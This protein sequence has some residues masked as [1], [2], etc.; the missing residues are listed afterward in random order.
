MNL[1]TNREPSYS[2][3]RTRQ[4][5]DFCKIPQGV[6]ILD[7]AAKNDL[8]QQMSHEKNIKIINTISDLDYSIIPESMNVFNYV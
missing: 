7:I 3:S 1:I 2:K 6:T 8:S 4:T 5:I